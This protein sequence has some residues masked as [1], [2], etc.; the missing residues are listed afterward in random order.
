MAVTFTSTQCQNAIDNLGQVIID[1]LATQLNAGAG[2]TT[3]SNDFGT[4]ITRILALTDQIAEP[5]LSTGWTRAQRQPSA[6]VGSS[7]LAGKLMIYLVSQSY[8]NLLN[9]G[10]FEACDV[11]DFICSQVAGSTGLAN[12]LA[13]NAVLVDQYSADVFNAYV[14]AVTSGAFTRLQGIGTTPVKIPATSVFPHSNVDT[15]NVFTTTS[16][17]AGTLAA[18][19]QSLA[20]ISGGNTTPGGGTLECYAGNTIGGASGNYTIT[21][22]YTSIAGLAAQTLTFTITKA[23]TS[24]TVM[25]PSATVQALSIQSVAITAG[26][27]NGAGDILNFRL[28]PVRTIAA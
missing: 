8:A 11:L 1:A 2:L 25:S 7:L 3:V 20:S 27:A 13:N 17:S 5:A 9:N 24:G 16:T 12:F 4:E 21:V 10:P 15:L 14:T 26:A 6:A 28:K 23:S 18:G 22:T 19:T